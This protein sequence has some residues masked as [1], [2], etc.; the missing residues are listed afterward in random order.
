MMSEVKT[1]H[2][3]P[4]F[5]VPGGAQGLRFLFYYRYVRT[6][7]YAINGVTGSLLNQLMILNLLFLCC[8]FV[9]HK[10]LFLLFL[11]LLSYF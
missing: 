2:L 8:L 3:S 4:N 7:H 6:R 10:A 1:C 9:T 5:P 11:S